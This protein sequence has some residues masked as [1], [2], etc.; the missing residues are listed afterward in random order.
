[1]RIEFVDAHRM[2][3]GAQVPALTVKDTDERKWCRVQ[4]KHLKEALKDAKS[5]EFYTDESWYYF[6]NSH[7]VTEWREVLA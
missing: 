5:A 3:Q 7:D 6:V 4:G 2:Q 1:M